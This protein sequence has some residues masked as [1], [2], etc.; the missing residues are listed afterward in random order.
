M[1]K[2]SVIRPRK[3][4]SERRDK[5]DGG[6]FEIGLA[7]LG[8]GKLLHR[9]RRSSDRRPAD[10]RFVRNDQAGVDGFSVLQD[11]DQEIGLRFRIFGIEHGWADGCGEFLLRRQRVVIFKKSE[12]L[13]G[14]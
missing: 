4:R 2:A 5:R 6:E 9:P 14:G 7:V 3:K 13:L 1:A 8:G 10:A 11:V 12:S